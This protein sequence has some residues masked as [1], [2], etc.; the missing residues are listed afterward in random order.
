M[1]R[2]GKTS[3]LSG[4]LVLAVVAALLF[5]RGPITNSPVRVAARVASS[6]PGAQTIKGD[7]TPSTA[8]A[9]P[10]H[11]IDVTTFEELRQAVQDD[12][13]P[14]DVIR[15][16]PGVYQ[17]HSPFCRLTLGNSG[18]VD[19]PITVRGII[20]G[21]QLPIM[22]AAPGQEVYRGFFFTRSDHKHWIF[23]NL[24]FR[25]LRGG[26]LYSPFAAAVYIQGDGIVVRNCRIHDCDQGVMSSADARNTLIEY[27]D[28]YDCGSDREL[29]YTHLLYMWDVSLVVRGCH[30]HDAHGG[31][32]FKS[33]C[34]HHI[35]EYNWLENEGS[36]TCIANVASGNE[37]NALWRGNVFIKRRTPS[38][39]RRML[40]IHDGLYGVDGTL[41]LI[42]NTVISALPE[43]IYIHHLLGSRCKVVLKNNL[44]A[45][46]SSDLLSWDVSKAQLTGCN[47]AFTTAMDPVPST[48]T[49]SIYTNVSVVDWPGRD[50]RLLQASPCVNGG[51]ACPTWR[52][53]EGEW[54]AGTPMQ[55]PDKL[56]RMIARPRDGRLDIGAFQYVPPAT[57]GEVVRAR[58]S[59]STRLH[60]PGT[61]RVQ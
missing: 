31:M 46:P 61:D 50:L 43:D 24:E 6:Q 45:G 27:C 3:V 8:A 23:E 28:V 36:E 38:V 18:T 7:G 48:L 59:R 39:Q 49:N 12:S 26:D 10:Q 20:N 13:K 5:T 42:N 37:N 35:L 22:E 56:L 40:D 21:N 60:E 1:I 58:S 14:G 47:N 57:G 17:L 15:V 25:N 44:F 16:H 55:E 19:K 2:S 4:V 33:R 51:D 34:A 30:L 54:V 52:N 41:T 53:R 32:L 29:G 11:Y 9:M